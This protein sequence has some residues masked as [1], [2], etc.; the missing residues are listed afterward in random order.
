MK[1]KFLAVIASLMP[2]VFSACKIGE[3]SPDRDFYLFEE[4]LTVSPVK[5]EY[6]Q[7]DFVWLESGIAG[8]QLTDQTTGKTVEVGNATFNNTLNVSDPFVFAP[9]LEKFGLIPQVGVVTNDEDFEENGSASVSFGCPANDYSMKI[10][11]QFKEKGGYLVYMNKANPFIQIIFTDEPDCSIIKPNMIPP[12]RADIGTVRLTF[13]LDDINR[14]KFDE[15]AALFPGAMID[16]AP[17]RASLDKK[18]AFF[19]W[20]K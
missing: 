3:D 20:V 19:V 15:Y 8:K 1:I 18:E 10:G 16:L 6:T 11:I 17:L 2:V 13:N 5:K 12:D 7:G 14:D 4:K 9:N